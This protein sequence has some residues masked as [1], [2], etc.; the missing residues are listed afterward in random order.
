MSFKINIVMVTQGKVLT[1]T[2]SLIRVEGN[3]VS[4]QKRANC[5]S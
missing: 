5:Y 2:A 1:K 4:E 3:I